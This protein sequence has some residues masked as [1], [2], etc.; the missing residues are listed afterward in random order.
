MKNKF[1]IPNNL[2][3][4]EN[5]IRHFQNLKDPSCKNLKQ[6][7][8]KYNLSHLSYSDA[9]IGSND[10]LH[11]GALKEQQKERLDKKGTTA[12]IDAIATKL[13]TISQEQ[14]NNKQ[15]YGRGI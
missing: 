1:T 9:F 7:H 12:I 4:E 10:E 11:C 14:S 6:S 8:P 5:R 15:N 13:E 3:A 2:Q